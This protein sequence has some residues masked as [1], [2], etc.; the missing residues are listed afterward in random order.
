MELVPSPLWGE[1]QDEGRKRKRKKNKVPLTSVLSP[2][3]RGKTASN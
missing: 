2:K 3:V 1:S